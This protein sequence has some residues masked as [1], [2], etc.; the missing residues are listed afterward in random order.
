MLMSIFVVYTTSDIIGSTDR[1]WDLL[2]EAGRLHPVP[3]NAE[4]TYLTMRSESQYRHYTFF[5][6]S[7]VWTHSC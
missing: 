2:Q 4:G 3:G 1:M 5:I 7:I 6:E